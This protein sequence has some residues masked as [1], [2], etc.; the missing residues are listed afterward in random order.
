[1]TTMEA[2]TAADALRRFADC[3]ATVE[4]PAASS[5]RDGGIG[6]GR[7]AL[8][9]LATAA[10]TL[11]A[12]A[13]ATALLGH[14]AGR[15]P[16]SVTLAYEQAIASAGKGSL[17][18]EQY[19]AIVAGV[20]ARA[21]A[22]FGKGTITI[23]RRDRDPAAEAARAA[24]AYG[25]DPGFETTLRA[26]GN[27]WSYGDTH[28]CIVSTGRPD[29][30]VAQRFVIDG[31]A[32]DTGAITSAH[33][34]LWTLHH[35]I[36]HCLGA[37]EPGADA[38]AALNAFQRPG[39]Q[40]MAV[41]MATYR[42]LNQWTGGPSHEHHMG[43][44]VSEAAR[45]GARLQGDPSFQRADWNRLA[46]MV[47]PILR[48]HGPTEAWIAHTGAVRVAIW[49]AGRSGYDITVNGKPVPTSLA[50]WLNANRS[51]PE[52]D[53]AAALVERLSA[54]PAGEPLPAFRLGPD[55]AAHITQIEAIASGQ[56][57]PLAKPLTLSQVQR[58][59]VA[60]RSA[61]AEQADIATPDAGSLA[62]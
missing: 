25:E 19:G 20:Q 29:Q 14:P 53:R 18:P 2:A 49:D 38:F 6:F 33:V 57:T 37:D 26:N 42:E 34:L 11:G 13:G 47:N 51:V 59:L 24:A 8:L 21:D 28:H 12:I 10:V 50:G 46:A 39:G 3:P 15:E 48:T 43:E 31:V 9:A 30:T 44:A 52:I 54:P 7:R 60:R 45:I 56:T 17:S 32:A 55:A 5:N 62:P 16:T 40:D 35:E 36:G 58:R 1:M 27:G 41:T 22:H 4:L 61:T 23:L